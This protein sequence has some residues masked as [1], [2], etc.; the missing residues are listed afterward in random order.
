M[1]NARAS[2]VPMH[3]RNLGSPPLTDFFQVTNNGLQEYNENQ[4]DTQKG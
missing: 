2:K 1:I 3:P 4:K